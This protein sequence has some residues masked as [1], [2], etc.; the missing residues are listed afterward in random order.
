[1]VV[2]FAVYLVAHAAL[3]GSS[4]KIALGRPRWLGNRYVYFMGAVF[5]MGMDFWA[6]HKAQPLIGGVP[7]WMGF[8]I[9]LSAVQTVGMIYMVRSAKNH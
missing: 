8:F 7:A 9:L 2:T 6:W 1:M 3:L 4:G 5:I